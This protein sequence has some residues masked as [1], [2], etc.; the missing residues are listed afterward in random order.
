MVPQQDGSSAMNNPLLSYVERHS[1][2][3]DVLSDNDALFVAAYVA[4]NGFLQTPE[5][6]A[7]LEF[8][9]NDFQLTLFELIDS[10]LLTYRNR[11]TGIFNGWVATERCY[12]TLE[13]MGLWHYAAYEV[14]RDIESEILTSLAAH[15][16][17]GTSPPTMARILDTLSRVPQERQEWVAFAICFEPI[18]DGDLTTLIVPTDS[19]CL[20]LRPGAISEL[21][22]IASGT[23]KERWTKS[24]N[25]S[26]ASMP[27]RMRNK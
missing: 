3:L 24:R 10:G 7:D 2:L 1:V 15:T 17:H 21:D 16:W 12:Q 4:R 20:E 27:C 14:P 18:D 6:E 11:D 8:E 9:A 5:F 23:D 19:D 22:K 13:A 25:I 26:W